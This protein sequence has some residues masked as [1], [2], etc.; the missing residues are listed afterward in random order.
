MFE[1]EIALCACDVA[2]AEEDRS[3][4]ALAAKAP[5][6]GVR[7]DPRLKAAGWLYLRA[8]ALVQG[9]LTLGIPFRGTLALPP[10]PSGV[11]T[12][13]RYSV[14]ARIVPEDAEGEDTRDEESEE[15]EEEA[16]GGLFA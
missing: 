15:E 14:W 13:A 9:D 4:E 10:L 6:R 8:Q 5:P 7:S 1:L 2:Q 3:A 11:S 12:L 16:P